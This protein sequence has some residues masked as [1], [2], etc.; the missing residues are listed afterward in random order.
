MANHEGETPLHRAAAP[1]ATR[2]GHTTVL[3][4]IQA[5]AEVNATDRGEYTPLHYAARFGYT[6]EASVLI[7]NGADVHA[8]NR[9]GNSPLH[10]AAQAGHTKTALALIEKGANVN[11][12]N[13]S[14]STA[15]HCAIENGELATALAII[16]YGKVSVANIPAIEGNPTSQY[17]QRLYSQANNFRTLS[18]ARGFFAGMNASYREAMMAGMKIY[19]MATGIKDSYLTIMN[20]LRDKSSSGKLAPSSLPYEMLSIILEYTGHWSSD[21]KIN[22]Q[23]LMIGHTSAKALKSETPYGVILTHQDRRFPETVHHNPAAAA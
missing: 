13:N 19:V 3:A 10:M 18:D 6:Q 7:A 20:L 12:T 14:G 5:G 2:H 11:A 21:L 1:W 8:T 16:H 23:D 22:L 4:L 9:D 15:L 17:I